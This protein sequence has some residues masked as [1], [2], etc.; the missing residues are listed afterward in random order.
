MKDDFLTKKYL[1]VIPQK[2]VI[3][4][5]NIIQES[6]IQCIHSKAD[7]TSYLVVVRQNTWGTDASD[8]E[9][10]QLSISRLSQ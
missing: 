10:V 5:L 1:R 8:H 9:F 3:S 7:D 6:L 2:Y 4:K